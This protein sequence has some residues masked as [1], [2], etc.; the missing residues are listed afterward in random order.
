MV[1]FELVEYKDLQEGD[2]FIVDDRDGIY[3]CDEP[4]CF[5]YKVDTGQWYLSGDTDKPLGVENNVYDKVWR[6]V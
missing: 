3:A 4:S 6:V 2:V 1:S 5:L